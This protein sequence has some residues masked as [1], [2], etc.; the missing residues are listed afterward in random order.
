VAAG[1]R[2]W[3]AAMASAVAFMVAGATRLRR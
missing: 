2:A 1:N 3:T